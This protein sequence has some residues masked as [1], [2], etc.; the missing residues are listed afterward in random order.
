MKQYDT[1]ISA[2]LQNPNKEF[3]AKD[4]Q[5]GQYFIGYEATARMSELAMMYPDAIKVGKDGRFR[6]LKLN[7]ENKD[8]VKE[9]EDKLYE[10]IKN[11]IPRMD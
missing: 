5:K 9:L 11:H 1:I 8:A 6:T 4:F 7:T 2:L 3:T 10:S